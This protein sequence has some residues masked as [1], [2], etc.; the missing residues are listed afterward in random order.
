MSQPASQEPANSPAKI[1]PDDALPAVNPPSAGFLIQLFVIPGI[2]VLVIVMVWLLFTWL[3]FMGG[4]PDSYL[5]EMRQNKAN[6]WQQAYNLSE[7]LRQN[8]EHRRD[9]GLAASV[10]DFLSDLL[11]QPLP[12]ATAG[13]QQSQ[14]DPRGEEIRRRGFLCKTLGEF[15]VTDAALPVL[16]RAASTHDQ[17]DDLRVRLAAL[18]AIALLAENTEDRAVVESSALMSLLRESSLNPDHKIR[19]RAAVA[20]AA[21][22][23]DE[24]L[25]CLQQMLDQPQHVDVH[26]N[27]ATGLARRGKTACIEMLREMLDPYESRGVAGEPSQ[28]ARQFKQTMILLNALKAVRSL[29]E[30]D[31]EADLSSLV[32]PVRQLA[33]WKAA[34]Q[35][36]LEAKLTLVV[37]QPQ[38]EAQDR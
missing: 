28:D 25:D 4:D 15:Y 36:R 27:V 32:E 13:R 30:S 19:L 20:L 5:K 31:P 21:V 35:V 26:Y 2:I 11:D 14:R 34:R 37:L 6:S 7:V 29:A 1:S 8:E 22:G 3:A 16:I 12:P 9:A 18:E 10:A 38:R 33:D 17:E 24:A 23:S